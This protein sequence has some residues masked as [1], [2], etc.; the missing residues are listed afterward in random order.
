MKVAFPALVLVVVLVWPGIL[1]RGVATANLPRQARSVIDRI[2][3]GVALAIAIHLASIIGLELW[4]LVGPAEWEW[5][6]DLGQ[7][8]TVMMEKGEPEDLSASAAPIV[9]YFAI[10]SVCMAILG[11]I[12]RQHLL[13]QDTRVGR[14]LQW[15]FQVQLEWIL[16]WSKPDVAVYLSTI[17]DTEAGSYLYHGLVVDVFWNRDGRVEAVALF[18]AA[19]RFYRI[20][21]D[22]LVIKYSDMSTVNFTYVRVR[23]PS[24][25]SR[26]AHR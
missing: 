24:Q 2:F 12:I 19:R 3:D 10:Q 25:P 8:F 20:V 26:W 6:V 22:R 13:L 11:T 17:V 21:G 5:H 1:L 23:L 15:L 18:D 16:L 4:A 9:S 14:I 7:V